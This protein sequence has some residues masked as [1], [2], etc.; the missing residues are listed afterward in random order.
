MAT[1]EALAEALIIDSTLLYFIYLYSLSV[2]PHYYGFYFAK[3][4]RTEQEW[5]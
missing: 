5:L 4:F 3:P 2:K 1:G